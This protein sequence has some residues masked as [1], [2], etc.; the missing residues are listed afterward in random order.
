MLFP[1]L[2][3]AKARERANAS[4]SRELRDSI[5]PV[6]CPTCGIYQ[7]DM[8][9]ELRRRY[10]KTYDPN[11]YASER[12]RASA[13]GAWRMAL[14]D[15]TIAAHKHFR[16]VWPT[17]T[18]LVAMAEHRIKELNRPPLLRAIFKLLPKLFWVLWGTIILLFAAIIVNVMI[19][20]S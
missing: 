5:E 2:A 9:D 17:A 18:L 3:A 13:L 4:L 11:A 8:V 19:H 20:H 12:V 16:E 10:G 6:D 14:A 7:P 15:D 1:G